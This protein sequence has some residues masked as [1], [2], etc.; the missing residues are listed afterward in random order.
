MIDPN[1]I[2]ARLIKD[3]EHVKMFITGRIEEP[4]F[5][6]CNFEDT[7]FMVIS[8]YMDSEI[9]GKFTIDTNMVDM[10]YVHDNFDILQAEDLRLNVI[11]QVESGD[12]TV[13]GG[14]DPKSLH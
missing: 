5:F 3:Y 13:I 9:G 2:K 8:V 10:Q 4:V 6:A 1:K 14:A 7:T 11:N 12:V